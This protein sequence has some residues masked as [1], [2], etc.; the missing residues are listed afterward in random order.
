MLALTGRWRN[1]AFRETVKADAGAAAL[2]W[3]MQDELDPIYM[4]C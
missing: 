4:G 3:R 2:A 1:F